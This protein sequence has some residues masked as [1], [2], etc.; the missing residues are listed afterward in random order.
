MPIKLRPATEAELDF[1]V[2]AE[3][4]PENRPFVGQWTRAQHRAALT[5]PDLAYYV[6]VPDNPARLVGYLILA[7]LTQSHQSIEFRRLVITEKGKGYGRAALRLVKKL[8]FETYQAHRLWLDVRIHNLRAQ[9]LYQAEGFVVEG[10]LRE[11]VKIDD[12]FES[13]LFMSIL[14]SE[15]QDSVQGEA[16]EIL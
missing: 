5:N 14:A 15:Y 10:A 16:H 2:N 8:A 12:H 4:D 1:I 6:I 3:S 9:R 7:G 11:C 13:L